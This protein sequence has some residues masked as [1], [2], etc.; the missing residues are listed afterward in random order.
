M[1]SSR[2][3][4]VGLKTYPEGQVIAEKL[5]AFRIFYFYSNTWK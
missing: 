4:S 5:M 2:M 3:L 1:D